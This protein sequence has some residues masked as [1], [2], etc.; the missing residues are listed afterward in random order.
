MPENLGSNSTR[1]FVKRL[2][3]PSPSLTGAWVTFKADTMQSNDELERLR[4]DWASDLELIVSSRVAQA[5][6]KHFILD[7]V[8]RYSVKLRT[9]APRKPKTPAR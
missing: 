7:L 4:D 2:R 8:S 1:F 6:A 9:R 3:R 5:F